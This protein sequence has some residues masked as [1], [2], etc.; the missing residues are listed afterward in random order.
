MAI[1]LIL[2][3]PPSLHP[4]HF[5][6]S[7]ILLSSTHLR[8]Q[9]THAPPHSRRRRTPTSA[10]ATT[11]L[12]M[13]TQNP[14]TADVIATVVS[15]GVA[16]TILR[17]F[18]ETATRHIFDSKLN[19]KLV[20]ISIGIAFML[21]WPMFS[22]GRRGAIF[23]ALIPGINVIKMLL[24]GLGVV[25]D[26]A[27]V[28]SMS[29][30]GDYRELLK[31]PLYYAATITLAC[32]VYWINSPI[33]FAAVCNLCAGDGLADVIG[34]RFGSHKLPYNKNKS[35]VGSISMLMA[36]F[37]AS[38]G[39]MHYFASFGYMTESWEMVWRFFVVSLASTLVESHPLSTDLDDNLT[40]PLASLLVGSLV[41]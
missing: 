22:D 27:T 1:S 17:L 35:I 11:F 18:Q 26:E 8:F 33:G 32:A 14:V 10:S 23:A 7:T 40:V 12:N 25:K 15:G 36:G 9:I 29:R 2:L 28:I 3:L 16:L 24:L 6:P 20:H 4:F 41:F 13:F 37:L 31:G 21:C 5:H 30:Y 19:R 34:R 38:I 39:F